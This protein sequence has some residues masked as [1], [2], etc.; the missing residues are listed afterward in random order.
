MITVVVVLE[1]LASNG[2]CD[3]EALGQSLY[4]LPHLAIEFLCGNAADAGICRVHAYIREIVELRENGELTELGDTRKEDEA[5]IRIA[6][7][8]WNVELTHNLTERIELFGVI[9]NIEQRRVVFVHKHNDLL[10]CPFTHMGDKRL[11][12]P[13]KRFCKAHTIGELI[14]KIAKD[15]T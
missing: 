1:A 14:L 12:A 4:I 3:V 8:K 10:A 5:K 7:F 9:Y 15:V 11:Q 6:R 2:G 13:A